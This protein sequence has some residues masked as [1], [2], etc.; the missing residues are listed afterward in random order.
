MTI[1][2]SQG[3]LASIQFGNGVVQSVLRDDRGRYRGISVDLGSTSIARVENALGADDIPRAVLRQFGGSPS[4][5]DLFTVD[6]AGRLTSENLGLP[7]TP[8]PSGTIDNAQILG[9]QQTNK[10]LSHYVLDSADNWLSRTGTGAFSATLDDANRYSTIDS[11][12]VAYDSAGNTQALGGTTFTFDALGHLIE[13]IKAPVDTKWTYDAL[14]RRSTETRGSVVSRILWDGATPI[15]MMNG[16]DL[17]LRIGDATLGT[18]AFA[19]SSGKVRFYVHPSADRSSVA[20][21]D[22][23]GNLLEGYEYSAYGETKFVS[24]TG[25]QAL[26]SSISNRFLYQGQ[27]FDSEF[28]LY[29]MGAREYSPVYGRFLSADPAGLKGGV[30]LYA[31]VG[32]RPLDRADPEGL[33]SESLHFDE[34]TRVKLEVGALFGGYAREHPYWSYGNRVFLQQLVD[35]IDHIGEPSNS[36][37]MRAALVPV[38]VGTVP[39]YLLETWVSRL[40]EKGFNSLNKFGRD[41]FLQ[42]EFGKRGYTMFTQFKS[43]LMVQGTPLLHEGLDDFFTS[44]AA[45]PVGVLAPEGALMARASSRAGVAMAML[46]SFEKGEVGVQLTAAEAIRV[47]TRVLGKEVTFENLVTGVSGR[48]DLV[49]TVPG[50]PE[51]FIIGLESKAGLRASFTPGQA[52]NIEW[53]GGDFVPVRFSGGNAE[54]LGF[55]PNTIYYMNMDV[56]R[57]LF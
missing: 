51:Q 26:G 57:W 16:D 25:T 13:A 54:S 30:N 4:S 7:S 27:V 18:L 33:S 39:L 44:M 56:Y 36:L 1:S 12:P 35:L 32:A 48:M 3:A 45:I 20:A 40:A 21:T 55:N 19:D 22:E 5:T 53:M 34:E 49:G 2:Y 14:D 50:L 28:G 10:P 15:G 52:V 24:P 9:L 17:Q 47:G 43:G 46:S 6:G 38:A 41:E 42:N 37:S 31:F 29:A 23:Q 8:L 11:Q